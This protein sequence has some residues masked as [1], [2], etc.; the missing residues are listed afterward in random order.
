M[1]AAFD[2]WAAKI[3]RLAHV[4]DAAAPEDP[5]QAAVRLAQ[6]GFGEQ[7]A[8]YERRG[9]WYF[10]AGPA[11]VLTVDSARVSAHADGFTRALP[12]SGAPLERVAE[13]LAAL[14]GGW[15]GYGW[16]AFELGHLIHAKPEDTGDDPLFHLMIPLVEVELT[17]GRARIRSATG[18]DLRRAAKLLAQPDPAPPDSAVPSAANGSAAADTGP[19]AYRRAVAHTVHDIQARRLDKAVLSR[20]LPLPDGLELDLFASYL[21]GRRANTPARSFLLDLGG[22]RAAGFSPETVVEIDGNGR[23]STQP[24]AGTRAL[25]PDAAENRRL[26]DDLLADPKEVHEHAVSVRLAFEEISGICRPGSVCVEEF[27]AVRER[28]AVQH[29]ASRVTG[30][31][32]GGLSP[33]S[34]FAAVFPAITATGVPKPAALEVIRHRESEPRGLYAGAVFM[35]G[36]DGSL[37]AALTLR[38]VFQRGGRSW[39]RV[40]AG[41]MG[42]ST[43][44]R[45]WEETCEKL[46]SVTPHLR[47]RPHPTARNP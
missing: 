29:L 45:E 32:R 14:P 30:A 24:L 3:P 36:A 23:V 43:P 34:A 15:R 41:I 40:G 17:P 7:Y 38:T 21:A 47:T 9:T 19:E 6:A 37:D 13:A 8:V 11:G 22:W 27:M 26:R 12:T 25:G 1:T 46:R 10:A 18:Q 35:A 42:Q 31:L 44:D 4:S 20:V 2:E 16:A 33:W 39:L 5:A 28:G